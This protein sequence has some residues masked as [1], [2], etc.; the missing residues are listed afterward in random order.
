MR[1]FFAPWKRIHANREKRNFDL[2]DF[3]ATFLVNFIMRIMGAIM[4][5]TIIVVGITT[6]SI[7]IVAGLVFFLL[8]ILVPLAAILFWVAG[9]YLIIF[10]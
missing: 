1:T 9:M 2:A 5:T 3:A 8:W 10:K 6:L 4:R 7:V